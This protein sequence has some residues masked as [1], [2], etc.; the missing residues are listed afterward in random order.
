MQRLTTDEVCVAQTVNS[1]EGTQ[2]VR[3]NDYVADFKNIT[4]KVD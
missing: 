4:E 2:A 3:S 1:A